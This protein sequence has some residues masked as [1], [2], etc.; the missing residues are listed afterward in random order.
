MQQE[1]ERLTQDL[2]H[3]R[4]DEARKMHGLFFANFSEG[5]EV[6]KF[7]LSRIFPEYTFWE[8]ARV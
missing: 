8:I 7:R 6:G 1:F 4:D 3:E 2:P 5:D